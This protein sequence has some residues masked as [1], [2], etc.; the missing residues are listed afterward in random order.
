MVP[1][2]P[3]LQQPETGPGSVVSCAHRLLRLHHVVQRHTPSQAAVPT[4]LAQPALRGACRPHRLPQQ[5]CEGLWASLS[6]APPGD[7]LNHSQEERGSGGGDEVSLGVR[8]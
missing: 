5:A 6:T 7:T 4:G 8:K 3:S 1:K 2:D